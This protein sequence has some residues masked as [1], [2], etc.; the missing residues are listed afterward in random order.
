M[1]IIRKLTV[2]LL[3]AALILTAA[4]GKKEEK[5]QSGQ[6]TPVAEAEKNGDI[7][8]MYTSDVH[9]GITQGFGYAGLEHIRENYEKQGYETILVDCGDS[10]QGETIGTITKG[11][12]IIDLM[13]K[14]KYDV[15]AP[16][17]HEFDYGADYFIELTKKADFPYVC[18]NLTKNGEN[19]FEPY[20]IKEVQGVKIAFVGIITPQTV[21]SSTP[22]YFQDENGNFIYDFKQGNS[23]GDLYESVQNAVDAA[24]AQGAN[25]VYALSHVGKE[26]FYELSYE[27][28]IRNTSGIDV[29]FDGHSHDYELAA[30]QNADGEDV[31]RVAV[32]SKLSGIGIS[33]I[34]AE[35][36]IEESTSI[37]WNNSI[38]AAEVFG[39]EN[40]ISK[41]IDDKMASLEEELGRVVAKTNYNLTIND[42]VVVDDEGNPVRMVR[43]AE[44][45]MADFCTDA[46]L[47]QSGA[48]I[49]LLN[50]GGIRADIRKGDISYN[51]ILSVFPFN[52]QMCVIEA[53]GQQILDALEWGAQ[54][55]PEETGGFLQVAGMT[56]EIDIS[57][58]SGCKRDE[59]NMQAGIEGE[60]RVK[61]VMIG[62]EPLD[63]DKTYTVAGIEYV[64]MNNGDGLTA[65]DGAKVV[66]KQA[67]LDS[68]LLIDYI[69]DEL[70]GEIGDAYADPHGQGRITV[71]GQ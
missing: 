39:I 38:C 11:E 4:C 18:C 30:V 13:N 21:T 33:K 43:R 42:P 10:I 15:A 26:A 16:G 70:G 3:V 67:K 63:P 56:Y 47:Q 36:G 8:V 22:A 2:L 5:P 59:N 27:D 55:A 23:F 25:Y 32:G 45:N 40:D 48:D 61:N 6:E 51:D 9:C 49:A 57:V 1:T 68:Q 66:K 58:P 12:D 53:T 69:T 60:R 50:G 54:A 7:I 44:T 62:G 41:A 28:I 64:L 29:F 19:V 71:T 14:M 37:T 17:N 20:T 52:N 46:I 35:N 31:E 34:S 24:R 65:F